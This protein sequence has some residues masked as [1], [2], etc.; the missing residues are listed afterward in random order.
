MGAPKGN[1][2]ALKHGLYAKHFNPDE[3]NELR[4]MS[5]VDYRHEIAVMRVAVRNVFNIQKSLYEKMASMQGDEKAGVVEELAKITNSLALAVTALGTMARTHAWLSGND[6]VENDAFQ[7]ALNS[8][9]IF[10][11]EKFLIEGKATDADDQEE[12]LIE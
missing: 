1:S 3:V 2:N 8:L 7:E 11:D 9:P 4:D 12:V 6:E 5:P 10:L